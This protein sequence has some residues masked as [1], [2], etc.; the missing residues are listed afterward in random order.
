[1][2]RR[3]AEMVLELVDR[4]TRPARRFMALQR[5]MGQAVERANRMA[6]RSSQAAQRATDLYRRAV[7]GLARAQDAL[8]RG[9]RRSNDLIRRQVTQMR[10]ATG[11]M[12]GGV[13]GMG[14]A[15]LLA[16]SMFTVY[17]G[18]V[19]LAA[20]SMLGVS[21]QFEKFNAVLTITEGSAE[22]ARKA[23]GWVEKF[24]MDTPYE[25]DKVMEAF[26]QLRA[27]GLDPT[28]GM[29][30]TLGDVAAGMGRDL[31]QP[32]E[33]IADAI[34]GEN[35][36]L[37]ELGITAS[38]NKGWIEYAYT[39]DGETKSKKARKGDR[40]AIM[41]AVLGIWNEKF[42]GA[43]ELQKGLFDGILSNIMDRWTKFRKM[44]MD[45]GPFDWMK[46]KLKQVLDTL[47][48]MAASGELDA[49]AKLIGGHMLEGLKAIWTF[50]E[51]AVW[52]FKQVHPWIIAAKDALGGWRNLALAVL[53]IPLR[54]VILATG[55]ALL[56]FAAGAALAM[57]ALAGIGLG[58]AVTGVLGF[59]N[60][61][62]A[63]ANPLNW[64]KGA[65][66]AL[67]VALLSTGIGA[68][69]VGLAM[70]G[71]WIHNNWSG[72][73][74]FFKGF[75][76]AFMKSLGPA[77]PLA[78]R[79]IRVVRRLWDWI[80]RLVAPLDA[81]AEQWAEWGRAAGRF[82]G[83]AANS[84]WRFVERIGTWFGNLAA[85]DWAKLLTI[86]GLAQAWN[87]VSEWISEHAKQLWDDVKALNWGDYVNPLNWADYLNP[88]NWAD[89]LSKL[90]RVRCGR[91]RQ[92]AELGGSCQ[93][94]RL[95]GPGG[96]GV[97]SE[98]PD[99]ADR[100]DSKA[101]RR[102]DPM[103]VSFGHVCP[104]D[105][106]QADRL[107][108]KAP[109]RPDRMGG[110]A[111]RQVRAENADH[112]DCVDGEA[113]GRDDRM[114]DVA[115]RQIRAV[116]AADRRHMGRAT[117]LESTL[118][119]ACR[120]RCEVRTQG[121]GDRAEMDQQTDPRHRL[122]VA[123]GRV[124]VGVPGQAARMGRVSKIE[125]LKKLWTDSTTWLGEQ[126]SD[127][128][129][130]MKE[131]WDTAVASWEKLPDINWAELFNLEQMQQDWD[132]IANWFGNVA[133]DLWNALPKINWSDLIN[134]EA[135][136]NAWSKVE[137]LVKKAEGWFGGPVELRGPNAARL[138]QAIGEKAGTAQPPATI[139]YQPPTGSGFSNMFPGAIQEKAG[140][141]SFN[142]GWLLT[143]ERG[144]ELEYRTRG[145][146]I[147]H[148]QALRSMLAM[149]QSVARNAANSN[150]PQRLLR[151]AALA[152]GIAAATA[153]PAAAFDLAPETSPEDRAAIGAR[154]LTER[155]AARGAGTGPITINVGDIVINGSADRQDLR[156][157]RDEITDELLDKV[158][159]ALEDNRRSARRWEHD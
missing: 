34:T 30:T 97:P 91:L 19:G 96:R 124:V 83:D 63:L 116:L 48:R 7:Q 23:M 123:G 108:G 90:T 92:P 133:S 62:L 75:G 129:Q 135:L 130:R 57:K 134:F 40:A 131:D 9:I 87:A 61:L 148:N 73:K 33:A 153:V 147:A 121:A 64:V 132:R 89:Y 120:R 95:A 136:Q 86:E 158:L 17:A 117:G 98:H 139:P 38:K 49:W 4:A 88:L 154:Y 141:G 65:F 36:R 70:A 128:W 44:I 43:M 110:A 149:S 77:R 74:A 46:S 93:G 144:P 126:L 94:N 151:R 146:F 69:A 138:G 16:G 113:P 60:A 103:G 52:F 14:R 39:I 105:A 102:P 119:A 112:A 15:A 55:L 32:V 10:L 37:K 142:P 145:G 152:G 72:L 76:E 20:G 100:V 66:I 3:K 71:V 13:M 156:V 54:G 81:S 47:D 109:G 58:S 5:R 12:R 25:L 35:E 114:G 56:Q 104:E 29:L 53:A 51:D 6:R 41:E 1:M 101:C 50:G 26:V 11:L 140:G 157:M 122:G 24:A 85:I 22:A 8:Q 111:G 80:G 79:V 143:G 155:N 42:G 18:T 68:L 84:V 99:P 21:R 159:D 115:G 107:D 67:R 82:V 150:R 31:M 27:Y 127:S 59:G 2:S 106:G 118:A 45:S 28:N 125:T 78:E 137:A